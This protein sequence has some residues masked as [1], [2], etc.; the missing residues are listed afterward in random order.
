LVARGGY[1]GAF[2][3]IPAAAVCGVALAIIWR[4]SLIEMM[5]EPLTNLF[6]GGNQEVEPAPF[7]S[8][9]ET[10]RKRGDYAGALAEIR[11]QL[12]RFPNDF[13]G[14]LLFAEIQAENL[15]DLSAADI[16]I[17]RIC[18]QKGHTPGNVAHALNSLADWNLKY[19]QDRDAAKAAL[20][21]II[22]LLPG[23]E[24]QALAAQRIAHLAE[25]AHLIGHHDRRRMKVHAG[26]ENIGLLAGEMHPRAPEENPEQQAADFVNHLQ[27]H[28]LD[29]EA[30]EK[31][32]V[33]YANF[34]Q[35]LDLAADQ[36]E[37]LISLPNQPA[38]RVVHWLNLL[39]DLQVQHGANR[40]TVQATLQRIAD[41]FPN[42]AAATLAQ[43]RIAHLKLEFRS[44]EKSQTVRLGSY[45]QDIGL[46][47]GRNE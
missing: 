32:A 9:A 21:R 39:A 8:I 43:S 15:N 36:L 6:D 45:E 42:S 1:A 28:P 38:G 12:E 18:N 16:S 35:R 3:G 27:A 13:Q 33:L 22:E 25:T 29:T 2:G 7:Y 41:R 24:F 19:A 31:L 4:G 30:R 11:R 26:I 37:H 20:E 44:K 23:T 14:Q 17:Q 47:R 5:I 10:K 34:Y 46:K 40:E